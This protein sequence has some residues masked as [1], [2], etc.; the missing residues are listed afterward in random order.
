MDR[1]LEAVEDVHRV[2]GADLE[3]LVVVVAARLSWPCSASISRSLRAHV[4]P[5]PSP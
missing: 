5:A 3:R 4:T 2:V 1:A